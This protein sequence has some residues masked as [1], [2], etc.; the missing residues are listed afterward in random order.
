MNA[1][2]TYSVHILCDWQPNHVRHPWEGEGKGGLRFSFSHGPWERDCDFLIVLNR[3][4]YP[5][6]H[7]CR[8]AWLF[9]LEPPT[10]ACRWYTAA[11][12]HFDRVYTCW[13][14]KEDNII[15]S[16]GFLPWH[17]GV[18]EELLRALPPGQ[19]TKQ[20]RLSCI[21]S[22]LNVMQ[23]HALRLSL[24]DYLQRQGL[25]FDLYG[26]HVR[27]VER[28]FDALYPYKYSLVVENTSAPHYWT[29]KLADCLL[30]WTLPVYYGAPNVL[31]YFPEGSLLWIDPRR[32]D[33]ALRSIRQAIDGR[34][35]DS[36]LDA[37]AEARRR[38]MDQ[39]SLRPFLEQELPSLASLPMRPRHIPALPA[40]WEE[41]GSVPLLRKA[42]YRLRKLFDL[43]PY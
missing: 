10:P 40:P 7:A 28:K 39:Y 42:E 22:S 23:G 6:T 13:P 15:P 4:K 12:S 8:Q 33:R 32:P 18:E 36:R 29:E 11:F 41:G 31:D 2:M 21:S 5:L 43:K 20:D 26:R 34:W 35:W 30:S 9:S 17:V 24:I 19:D 27:P 14:R 1:P 38:I 3:P 25:D 37:I 16:H